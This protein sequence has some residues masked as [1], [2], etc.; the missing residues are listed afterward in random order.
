MPFRRELLRGSLDT[1][2]L[3]ALHD[4]PLYGYLIQKRVQ[5]SSQG[6][7][8]LPVGTLYPILYRLERAGA[9]ASQTEG[10]GPRERRW[11][12]LTAKGR[13]MLHTQ[14][15]EWRDYAAC[16]SDILAPEAPR[17]LPDAGG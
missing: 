11:Y 10:E 4:G 17:P 5:E 15:A 7:V 14:C 2:V 8:Q 16:L 13:Q 1:V 3:S 6:K 9:V 12:E